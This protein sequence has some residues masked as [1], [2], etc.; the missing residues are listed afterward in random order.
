MVPL[1]HL[2]L[3]RRLYVWM[4]KSHLHLSIPLLVIPSLL[5]STR[6]RRCPAEIHSQ[7]P[8][9]NLFSTQLHHRRLCAFNIR[10]IRM[11]KSPRLASPPINSDAHICNVTDFAE[12]VIKFAV[13]DLE[14]HVADEEGARG[15]GSAHTRGAFGPDRRSALVGEGDGQSPAF[16]N[17]G[18]KGGNG[19]LGGGH[20]GEGYVTKS[21]RKV[22]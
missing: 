10:E 9:T 14:G 3:P 19:G 6:R 16:K 22:Y 7:L 18:V 11:R 4:I 2:H 12:E 20:V 17:L 13:G 5:P 1:K 8:P 21:R 15:V